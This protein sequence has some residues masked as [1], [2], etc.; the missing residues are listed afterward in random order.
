[1]LD[2]VGD[3][4]RVRNDALIGSLRAEIP[5]LGEHLVRRTQIERRLPLCVAVAVRLLQHRAVDGIFG[6]EKV[7]I[8]GRNEGFVQFLCECVHFAVDISEVFVRVNRETVVDLQEVVVVDGLDLEEVVEFCNLLK[9]L[10]RASR[11]DAA[12]KLACLARRAH[13][14]SLT[15]LLEHSA[16][17]TR[18]AALLRPAEVADMR[19]RNEFVEI[20]EPRLILRKENDV[21]GTRVVAAVDEVALHPVDDLDIDAFLLE[22]TRRIHSLRECLHDAVIGDGDGGPAPAC[23]RLDEHLRR[24]DGIERAHLRMGVEL[25]A[26]FLRGIL[27][28]RHYAPL[29]AVDEEH[30]VADEF[31]VFDFA[32][33][34]DG[35]SLAD[36]LQDALDL[37]INLLLG[38]L[39]ACPDEFLACDAICG[40]GKFEQEDI[41]A[42]LELI[43]L[44]S[45]DLAREHDI[46]DLIFN[47]A[48][49]PCLARNAPSHDDAGGQ[50]FLFARLCAACRSSGRFRALLFHGSRHDGRRPVRP[51]KIAVYRALHADHAARA[52]DVPADG[53]LDALGRC[54]LHEEF[55]P[56]VSGYGEADDIA[57]H[58]I[59]RLAQRMEKGRISSRRLIDHALPKRRN[60]AFESNDIL[61][62]KRLRELV[63][64]RNL[65]SDA[66]QQLVIEDGGGADDEFPRIFLCRDLDMTQRARTQKSPLR[67]GEGES[68]HKAEEHVLRAGE[69]PIGLVHSS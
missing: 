52:A 46:L 42:G 61:L 59:L 54:T 11:N 7:H 12:D 56:K 37:R 69:N 3:A 48:E 31:V 34:P 49:C 14:D 8:A 63:I 25:D 67:I 9:F 20:V 19:Q 35:T 53:I 45:E 41:G 13:D 27:A 32:L 36:R 51:R 65:L 40:I 10:I 58:C 55:R 29:H 30:V 50:F 57:V 26:L 62:N 38:G 47:R 2:L 39:A 21:I 4:A 23:R 64:L 68:A 6:I 44:R 1:M 16:R 17:H 60:G 24:N 15:V 66:L 28:L 22:C 5:E 33:N 18:P 43:R